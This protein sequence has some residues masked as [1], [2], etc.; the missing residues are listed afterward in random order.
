[1][2]DDTKRKGP[3]RLIIDINENLHAE[4]KAMASLRCISLRKYTLR[5]LILQLNKD[6]KFLNESQKFNNR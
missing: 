4:V 5:A 6:Q 3:K 2:I 1:M